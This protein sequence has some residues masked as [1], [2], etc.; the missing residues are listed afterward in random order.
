MEVRLP[1]RRL[2]LRGA[3]TSAL[4]GVQ[5]I[6]ASRRPLSAS[7]ADSKPN[8]WVR[9]PRARDRD[10]ERSGPRLSRRICGEPAAIRAAAAP[11]AAPPADEMTV[12]AAWGSNPGYCSARADSIPRPSSVGSPQALP[13]QKTSRLAAPGRFLRQLLR[14][15]GQAHR[16]F[17]E[18]GGYIQALDLTPPR[19]PSTKPSKSPRCT[20]KAT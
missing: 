3:A 8:A 14:H 12:G 11:R 7:A 10:A 9:G 5:L 18:W 13:R 15:T 2:R 4:A 6:A 19:N 1:G 16:L 17:L 20:G